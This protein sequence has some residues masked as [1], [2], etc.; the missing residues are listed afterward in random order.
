[1]STEKTETSH[2][3]NK[4]DLTKNERNN[5]ADIHRPVTRETDDGRE[6]RHR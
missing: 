5:R 1:M 4:D 3:S 6:K 2:K